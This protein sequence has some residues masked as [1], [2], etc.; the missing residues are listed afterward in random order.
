MRSS[1]CA[2]GTPAPASSP[3]YAAKVHGFCDAVQ[4]GSGKA[5]ADCRGERIGG[6][7]LRKRAEAQKPLHGA[8][9]LELVGPAVA[10][11]GLL[12]HHRCV[13][14]YTYAGRRGGSHRHTARFAEPKCTLNI[15]GDEV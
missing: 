15:T 5:V 6:V 2:H 3:G 7:R 14:G 11:D 10:D 13:F 9:D 8:L 4:Y 1:S 12:D